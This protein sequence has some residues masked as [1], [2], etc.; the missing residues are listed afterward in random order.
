MMKYSTEGKEDGIGNEVTLVN[1]R[2]A[3]MK[4]ALQT[5]HCELQFFIWSVCKLCLSVQEVMAS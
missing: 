4:L 5:C 2:D 1:V 3:L